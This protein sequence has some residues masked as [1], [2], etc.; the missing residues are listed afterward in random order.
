M[1]I[2]KIKC[3]RN[4]SCVCARDPPPWTARGVFLLFV[5]LATPLQRGAG[6]AHNL[7]KASIQTDDDFC[8]TEF[9]ICARAARDAYTLCLPL[10][11]WVSVRAIAYRPLVVPRINCENDQCLSQFMLRAV[12]RLLRADAASYSS[13]SPS[14][15]SA[16][17]AS[18]GAELLSWEKFKRSFATCWDWDFTQIETALRVEHCGDAKSAPIV[19]S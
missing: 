4:S 12:W 16:G 8:A 18:F 6:A 13:S 11:I 10:W 17:R 14:L 9:Q 7:A 1:R 2:M 3:T 15:G 5:S 19:D